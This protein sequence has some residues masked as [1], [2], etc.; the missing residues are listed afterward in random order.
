MQ[1]AGRAGG[2]VSLR[3]RRRAAAHARNA[4]SRG[5]GNSTLPARRADAPTRA[6]DRT[7]NQ[8]T[9]EQK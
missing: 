4:S 5:S 8:K 6:T 3:P 7:T 1:V 9:E 2:R